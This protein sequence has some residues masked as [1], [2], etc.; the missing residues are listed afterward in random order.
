MLHLLHALS[1][2]G[3]AAAAAHSHGAA[4]GIAPIPPRVFTEPS[5]GLSGLDHVGTAGDP[6]APAGA[7][8]HGRGVSNGHAHG[9]RARLLSESMGVRGDSH[10]AGS[11]RA[12]ARRM[13][14]VTE[15]TLL[16]AILYAFQVWKTIAQE[17]VWGGWSA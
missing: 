7:A 4:T 16:K 3:A 6:T 14:E 13:T 15:R 9:G 11:T 1:D 17:A 12:I 5:A 8:E 10:R 2:T